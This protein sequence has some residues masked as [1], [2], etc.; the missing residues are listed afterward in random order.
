[1]DSIQFC[2]LCSA[3]LANIFYSNMLQLQV[4]LF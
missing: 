4:N 3:L 2:V 1:M